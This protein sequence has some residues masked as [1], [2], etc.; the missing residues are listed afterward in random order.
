[1]LDNKIKKNPQYLGDYLFDILENFLIEESSFIKRKYIN[2]DYLLNI[3][4]CELTPTIRLVSINWIIMIHH[5]V[6][7]FKENTLFLT[8]QIIDRFLSKKILSVERTELL[9]LCSLILSSKHEEIDYVNMVESL[10]LSSNKFSK[11]DIINMQYEIL[12]EL[13][14][15]LI[16][17]TMNDYYNI[18]CTILNLSEVDT[19]KGLLLLNIVLVDYHIIKYPNF[20][21]S[22]GVVKL[23]YKKHIVWLI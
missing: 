10:Q 13:N 12:N 9:I 5:K 2:P 15:E 22:L 16:I 19:N 14:F 21:I 1:M 23:I 11:E 6:F 8:V 3:N 18:Y 7:E 20:L 4:N 17:P